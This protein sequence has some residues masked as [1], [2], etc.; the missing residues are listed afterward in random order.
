MAVAGGVCDC[1][2]LTLPLIWRG[3]RGGLCEP[4]NRVLTAIQ[5]ENNT[6]KALFMEEREKSKA[7]PSSLSASVKASHM[8][9]SLLCTQLHIRSLQSTFIKYTTTCYTLYSM[10]Y[11]PSAR[12]LILLQKKTEIY[13]SQ[14]PI[15]AQYYIIIHCEYMNAQ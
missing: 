14:F 12:P 11:T 10:V 9:T 13:S 5:E 3:Q 6:M 4:Q 8:G 7:G 2:Y 15:N 1:R